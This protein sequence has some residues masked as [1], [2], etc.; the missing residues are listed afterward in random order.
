MAAWNSQGGKAVRKVYE[1]GVKGYVMVFKNSPG[2][3]QF[4]RDTRRGMALQQPLLV[5]QVLVPEERPFSVELSVTDRQRTRRRLILS[6]SFTEVKTTPLHCQ[7]PMGAQIRKGTWMNLV[8]DVAGLVAA[9]FG[10]QMATVDLLEVGGCCKLRRVFTVKE[11]PPC[12]EGGGGRGGGASLPRALNFPPGVQ[13]ETCVVGPAG[14]PGLSGDDLE[15][16]ESAGL[17]E[18]DSPLG[19]SR[20]GA[21]G[22]PVKGGRSLTS[23]KSNYA[24]PMHLAFG[25][26][27]PLPPPASA[28][29]GIAG[30]VVS[31]VKGV[32]KPHTAAG[33]L[34]GPSF[35]E[36]VV[37]PTKRT[38]GAGRKVAT[39]VGRVG[40]EDPPSDVVA[41]VGPLSG[42]ANGSGGGGRGGRG[43][44]VVGRGE[45]NGAGAAANGGRLERLPSLE[46]P[47]G[48]GNAGAAS[49]PNHSPTRLK[50]RRAA[51]G[52][53]RL[54]V[55]VQGDS[56]ENLLSLS[57]DAAEIPDSP[58]VANSI[59]LK[60]SIYSRHRYTDGDLAL[61][62][63]AGEAVSS[64]KQ[65]MQAAPTAEDLPLHKFPGP[66]EGLCMPS[67]S[68]IKSSGWSTL[69]T[70]GSLG[71]PLP[72]KRQ[73]V[74]PG[75]GGGGGGGTPRY[76]FASG[77]RTVDPREP[78]EAQPAVGSPGAQL[79]TKGSPPLPSNSV[80]K[81]VQPGHAQ[82]RAARMRQ[83]DLLDREDARTSLSG[84]SEG[85]GEPRSQSPMIPPLK[86]SKSPIPEF[87]REDFMGK[88]ASG[89][90][91]LQLDNSLDASPRAFRDVPDSPRQS[92]AF[93]SPKVLA[94]RG[95]GSSSELEASLEE[96][97]AHGLH[98]ED[99]DA[100]QLELTPPQAAGQPGP[101]SAALRGGDNPM[102]VSDRFDNDPSFDADITLEDSLN[103]VSASAHMGPH[104]REE[105][106]EGEKLDEMTFLE[107][108]RI[109]Q[110]RHFTPPVIGASKLLQ[111]P[112]VFTPRK[113]LQSLSAAASPDSSSPLRGMAGDAGADRPRADGMMDLIYDP[114]L[115]CYYDAKTNKYFTL[116]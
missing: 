6:S 71:S 93:G 29:A 101:G 49:S 92:G 99:N 100:P 79:P 73:G 11:A 37:S 3:M 70:D 86:L 85:P 87:C 112:R 44:H 20:V 31:P 57:R 111:S 60:P 63:A 8:I 52:Y 59:S 51:P 17:S 110:H 7:M 89:F 84:W 26:R 69:Y 46:R 62:E 94:A 55:S 40:V 68:P 61:G 1:K 28:A 41:G 108:L 24:G 76:T 78:E 53:D 30:R 107:T 75:A 77:P 47:G 10:E 95:R 4:P 15:S 54:N 25:S 66:H 18:E 12:S 109:N 14:M 2:R 9:G 96:M 39:A 88:R 98:G 82:L 22:E 36:E 72:S 91:S 5:L 74:A 43:M 16:E 48:G 42:A 45:A 103:D 81:A 114:I 35:M 19:V 33:A 50:E 116:K 32:R 115:N 104:E 113:P 64:M 106:E 23:T 27:C 67:I 102:D 105:E 34:L 58:V 90:V 65:E 80:L 83:I 38:R 97:S 21:N 13:H 56:I